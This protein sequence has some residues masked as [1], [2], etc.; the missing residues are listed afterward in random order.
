M[1]ETWIVFAAICQVQ[2]QE[3]IP[4]SPPASSRQ[5]AA[6]TMMEAAPSMLRLLVL[7]TKSLSVNNVGSFDLS[8]ADNGEC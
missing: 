2:M 8:P 3:A 1:S 5:E 6:F 7:M 4:D